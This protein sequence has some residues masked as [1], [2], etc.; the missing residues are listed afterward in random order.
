MI[1]WKQFLLT[2]SG[3]LMILI[4]FFPFP[5]KRYSF[6]VLLRLFAP[7]FLGSSDLPSYF[8]LQGSKNYRHTPQHLTYICMHST[9]PPPAN[10]FSNGKGT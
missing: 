6:T 4:F 5:C 9:F 3:S 1:T 8:S 7:K 10:A 2:G